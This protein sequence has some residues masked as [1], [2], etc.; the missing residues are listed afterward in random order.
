M[1]EKSECID[2]VSAQEG[3]IYI[4]NGVA[5]PERYFS[6]VFSRSGGPGGQN[7]NKVNTKAAVLF[8]IEHCDAIPEDIRG[9]LLTKLS[10]RINKDGILRIESSEYR[11]QGGNREA[12]LARMQEL[13]KN[14][15]AI[16]PHR[17][18][19]RVPRAVKERR[20]SLKKKRSDLKRLR[21]NDGE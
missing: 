10:G 1:S 19:T 4:G 9:R 15:L 5:V 20:L 16:K 8:D 13:L 12:A 7:V 11:T 2:T 17:K 21:R 14:A 6:F 18:K 3:S